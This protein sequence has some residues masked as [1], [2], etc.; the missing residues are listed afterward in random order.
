MLTSFADAG[1]I[2]GCDVCVVGAGP[3]GIA[4][5]LACEQH[6]LT[7]LLLE[8]GHEGHDAFAASLTAG[9]VVDEQR[10]AATGIAISRGLGGTSRWWGG[11]CVP[12]DDVDFSRRPHSPQSAWPIPHQ[13]IARWYD[14]AADFFG[15]GPARFTTAPAAPALGDIRTDQLE[16][17]TPDIDA[18]RRHSAHLARSRLI[19]VLKGAT[20]T[21]LL[22]SDDGRRIT[23]LVAGNANRT[24]RIVPR[25][26]VL[27]C[28]GLETTRLLLWTQQKRPDLFGGAGGA[29]GR[30]YMGHAS[31]KIADLVLADPAA[32]VAYDFFCDDC[33]YVRRRFTLTR[34]AQLREELLN[35]AFWLDNPPFH[36]AGH[37]NGVLSLVW[38]ALSIPPIGRRLVSE[39]IRI[40]HLG[41]KPHRWRSHLRNVLM[42]PIAT[43]RNIAA[44]A[45]ARFLAKPRQP[46]FLIR[47]AEGRY[48]LHFHA[49]QTPIR[50]SRIAL[51]DRKD[52]L[53]VPFLDIDL[54]YCEADARSVLRAHEILDQSLRS[55]G[56]GRLDY[57]VPREMRL[58]SILQQA[59]DGFHQIG[60]ARMGL[61]PDDSVVDGNC[62]VHGIE[63]LYISS[64]AVFASSGEANPTFAAVAL[65]FRLA[66]H[67][68]EKAKTAAVGVAA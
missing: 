43:L 6:G 24:C 34:D 4:L 44:I 38:M 46:G 26:T 41:E 10:H 33:A 32:V 40:I 8:S 7:V 67:L 17:W 16:R 62:R 11:R 51:S 55:A 65:A 23:G 31:G 53:G 15:I 37:R 66:A 30:F 2:G 49:E 57:R 48:A 9:H 27:A 5:A 14:A 59:R 1:E 13:D 35:I 54:R 52:A 29:L 47:S 50:E 68:A 45:Q 60:T 61:S 12:L 39:A 19:T 63:N 3:A 42:S 56:Y 22:V 64:S 20:V 36:Q 21:E 18:G 28:G 58:T 25:R